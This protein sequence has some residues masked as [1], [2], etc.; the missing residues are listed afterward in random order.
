MDYPREGFN[1]R[2]HKVHLYPD[3]RG[4]FTLIE[5]FVTLGVILL[6]IGILA[7]GLMQARRTAQHAINLAHIRSIGGAVYG[8][9]ADS[10]DSPPVI[11][12]PI[13]VRW[14]A[15]QFLYAEVDGRT[16]R[17]G[18]FSN[19][20]DYH[21][22]MTGYLPSRVLLDATRRGSKDNARRDSDFLLTEVLYAVPEYWNPDTQFG[23]SQW[24]AMPMSRIEHPSAK[25]LVWQA[26][27]FDVEGWPNGHMTCCNGKVESAV[28]WADL[29]ASRHVLQDLLPGVAN[30]YH[31]GSSF[32][33][34]IRPTGGMSV[35][36]TR[37]GV[38]G[39]DR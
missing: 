10:R 5:L 27:T 37:D 28:G 16:L 8:Y 6:L 1:S 19:S 3:A 21:N 29:S 20:A 18:W 39:R 13:Y 4:G 17:G 31:E 34:W 14:S 15:G 24:A 33:G 30:I 26:T 22:V 7:P 23:V 12:Q 32:S 2:I 9:A 38:R 36:N 25:G 11:F 35:V